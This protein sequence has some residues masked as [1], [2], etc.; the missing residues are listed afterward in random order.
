RSSHDRIVIRG[1]GVLFPLAALMW[2][3]LN[4]WQY[5][6]LIV[7]LLMVAIISFLDDIY[8]LSNKIRLLVQFTAAA[9]VLYQ[10]G[11]SEYNVWLWIS[12]LVLVVGWKNAFNFMDGINGITALYALSAIGA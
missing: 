6:Y 8:T 5:P 11:L 3:M 9:L 7:G 12:M 1:G 4:G 2:A 10:A